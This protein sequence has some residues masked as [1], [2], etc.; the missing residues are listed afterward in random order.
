MVEQ[1]R[2]Q[3][4]ALNPRFTFASFVVDSGNKAAYEVA[5]RVARNPGR[6]PDNPLLIFG[7]ATGGG[8][9]GT[10]HLMHAIGHEARR[11]GEHGTRLITSEELRG[12]F[13]SAQQSQTIASLRRRF[14]GVRLLLIDDIQCCSISRGTELCHEELSL[15]VR[16]VLAAGGQVVATSDRPLAR[17]AGVIP[18]LAAQFDGGTSVQ[19]APPGLPTRIAIL[20]ALQ[21][22]W[23]L[24]DAVIRSLAAEMPPNIRTLTNAHL[25]AS[26]ARV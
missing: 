11:M 22:E 7:S 25:R 16:L 19:V 2:Q 5:Y 4:Q 23:P 15:A 6:G 21:T 24:D 1:N 10:T 12:E 17:L 26:V 13:L 14:K 3:Q 8:G 18:R 20:R 9:V